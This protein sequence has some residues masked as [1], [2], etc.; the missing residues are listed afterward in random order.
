MKSRFLFLVLL[1]LLPWVH[2]A[3]GGG[4]PEPGGFHL[5]GAAQVSADDLPTDVEWM[6]EEAAET[7]IDFVHFN[8]TTGAFYYPEI[9][10]SGVA[11]L[12]YDDDGDLDVYMVQQ[13]ALD[14]TPVEETIWPPTGPLGDRLYRNDLTVDESGN[15]VL[16][17]TDVTE[18]AGIDAPWFGS[19][20]ATGDYDN[21]GD[22]DMYIT[23]FESNQLYRNN[24]DGTFSDVT[25]ETGTND[26]RWGTSVAFVDYDDDGWLDLYI[27]NYVDFRLTNHKE[28]IAVTGA[29]DYC[30]PGTYGG[31]PDS[32]FRNRGDGTFE[33][34][35]LQSRISLLPGAGLGV[36][37]GD[38]SGDGLVD[39]YVAN[40]QMVNF[41][42]VNQGDGTFKNQAL[43]AGVAVNATGSPESSMGIDAADFDSDGDLDLFMTHLRGETN[44]LYVNNGDG[45]FMDQTVEAGLGVGSRPSTGFGTTWFDLNNDGWLDLFMANGAVTAQ[46]IAD[47][48]DLFSPY[49]EP[50]QLFLNLGN[51]MFEEITARGG[52]VFE[53]NEV[54][55]GAAFGDIDNDGDVDIVFSNN[56]GPARLLRNNIGNRASW[57]GLRLVPNDGPRDAPGARVA[58]K[59]AG[60]KPL[61]REVRTVASYCSANDPR[62]MVGLGDADAVESIRV[63]WPRG[64]AEEWTDVPVNE[65]TTLQQG[66]GVEVK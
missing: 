22:V 12:D 50:N 17:F 29:Q 20:I 40:D 63:E 7:G 53:L 60:R 57:V 42:W 14:G 2:L 47:P 24:G 54:S 4:A 46:E 55:R 33:D 49:R 25:E 34:V 13:S 65:W 38:L 19:G 26:D 51:G 10:G 3:C 43:M 44:T 1:G 61:W 66:T 28:C 5:G 18:E 6:T 9:M 27:A 15:P 48:E 59:V 62:V 8:G 31:V 39:I 37:T 45:M 41:Y 56:A 52:E 58:V 11:L 21:D 32:L 64:T 16:R 35:S 36:V 23:N 30:A